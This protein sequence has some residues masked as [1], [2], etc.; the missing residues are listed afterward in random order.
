MSGS[1]WRL[2]MACTYLLALSLWP[3]VTVFERYGSSFALVAGVVSVISTVIAV[4][5][6]CDERG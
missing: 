5:L 3:M 4:V 6:I 1:G 2:C